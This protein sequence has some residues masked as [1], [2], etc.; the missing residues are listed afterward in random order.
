MAVEPSLGRVE[1]RRRLAARLAKAGVEDADREAMGLIAAACGLR[2]VDWILDPEAPLGPAAA[3]VEA[4]ARRREAGEPLTRILGRRAFWS[5]ELAVTPDVLDPRADTETLIEAALAEFGARRGAALRIVDFG[6]G[7]GP[8]LA[9]LLTEFPAAQGLGVDLSPQAA[10][11]AA[12]NVDTLGLSARAAVRVGRWGE[13]LTGPYDLIVSNPPYIRSGDIAGLAREV[14]EHDPKLALDGGPDGL[15]AYRELASEIMRLL[16][17]G[18]RFFVEIGQGQGDDVRALFAAAGL[19]P[20]LSRAD[21]AGIER[22]V[23]GRLASEARGAE[24]AAREL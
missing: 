17:P 15:Q 13:G 6:V 14:R 24:T 16:A 20:E 23:G 8:L 11:V 7:S 22:V 19:A 2:P 10:A 3:I 21:L 1:A 12:Q 4:L 5:L 9:A 18:G